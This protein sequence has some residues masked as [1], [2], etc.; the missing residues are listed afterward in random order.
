MALDMRFAARGRAV[1]GQPE[2]SVGLLPG[3]GGTQR[4][5]RLVGG[6][7]ALELIPGAGDI[8]VDTAERWGLV[9]RALPAGELGTFVEQLALRIATFPAHTPAL[10]KAAVNAAE[11]PL[12]GGPD[13]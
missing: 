3:G 1:F 10:T 5:P 9:N 12:V 7:R 2:V 6:A 13:R 8:D 11:G 4:L